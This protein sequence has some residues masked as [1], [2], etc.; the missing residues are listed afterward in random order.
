MKRGLKNIIRSKV[1]IG[2]L[3]RKLK[4]NGGSLGRPLE[5][6]NSKYI[7]IG[8]NVRI[9]EGIRINCYDQFAGLFLHPNLYIG[10]G[11]IFNYNCC[12]FC[13]DEIYIGKD[14]IFAEG[15][16]ITSENHGI[17]PNGGV[18]YHAQPLVSAPVYIGEGGWIG[19][20][21]IILPGAKI[22]KKCIVAAGAVVA[23]GNYPDFSILAGVPAKIIK[24]YNFE[25]KKWEKYTNQ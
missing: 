17:D 13:S 16:F 7:T 2:K 19:E 22:G 3:K 12:I 6:L 18:P 11:V 9:K 25:N 8:K 1:E 4:I 10:D 5:I 23:R 15:V 24:R 14:T 20:R 21:A